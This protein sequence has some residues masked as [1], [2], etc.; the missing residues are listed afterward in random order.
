MQKGTLEHANIS[1]TD[2]ARSA[3]LLRDLLGWSVRWEGPAMNGGHTIHIG[4]DTHYLALYTNPQTAG[5]FA[6]SVPLN[7]LGLQ[8]SD[9]DGAEEVVKRHG[10]IPFN[11]GDYEPGRRFY[12]MD[13]DGIEFEVLSYE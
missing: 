13:W 5:D 11:H 1:V 2:P 4:N 7:H 6:K 3:R 10:L 9:L 12:F 8:V